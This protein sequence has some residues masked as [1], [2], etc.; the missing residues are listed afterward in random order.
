M[1]PS[2][3][4]KFFTCVSVKLPVYLTETKPPIG[5]GG[6]AANAVAVHAP[7]IP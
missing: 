2:D 4:N 1:Y 3:P 6:S 5:L 7:V